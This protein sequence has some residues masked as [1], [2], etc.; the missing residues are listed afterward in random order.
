MTIYTRAGDKGKTS[1]ID[2]KKISKSHIRLEAYGT[3][4]ELNS[5]LGFVIANLKDKMIIKV[6]LKIQ[7]DLFEAGSQLASSKRNK[8]IDIYL[9]KRVKEFEDSIDKWAKI[10]PKLEHFVLPGGARSGSALHL[11]RTIC[12]RAERRVVD[13]SKKEAVDKNVIMYLNRLSDLL[14]T[15]ARV[16]NKKEKHKEIVW[17]KKI[18]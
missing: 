3:V 1:L 6:L 18:G 7:Q 13:L 10:L 16:I 15:M 9:E 8:K 14:F 4:D 11:S 12:R 5:S 17:I 2:G